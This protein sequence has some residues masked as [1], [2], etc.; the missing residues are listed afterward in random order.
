MS[1]AAEEGAS[2]RVV[3]VRGGH[4][5][6]ELARHLQSAERRRPAVVVTVPAGR[7]DPLIDVGHIAKEVAGLADV[8]LLPTTR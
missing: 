6:A 1:A 4:R 8:Y 7:V 5:A 2:H 3:E